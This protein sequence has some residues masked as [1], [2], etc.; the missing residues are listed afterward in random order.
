MSAFGVEAVNALMHILYPD[1]DLSVQ[2]EPFELI[3]LSPVLAVAP[4]E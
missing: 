1:A 3:K 4:D 2:E